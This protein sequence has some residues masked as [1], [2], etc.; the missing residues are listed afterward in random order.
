[1]LHPECGLLQPPLTAENIST[2]FGKVNALQH[3]LE[4]Q[5]NS[6]DVSQKINATK[7]AQAKT[8]MLIIE[9]LS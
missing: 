2:F 7:A 5:Y 4:G 8:A 6:T 9:G 3:S 1:L